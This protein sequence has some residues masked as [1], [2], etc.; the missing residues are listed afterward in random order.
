VSRPLGRLAV[1]L[2][3]LCGLWA[4]GATPAW[5]QAVAPEQATS[6]LDCH[7]VTEQA[8]TCRVAAELE[9]DRELRELLESGFTNHLVY[10]VYLFALGQDDP[11]AVSLVAFAQVFRLYTDVYYI[12]REGIDGY[13]ERLDWEAAAAELSQFE[14]SFGPTAELTPGDY[15]AVAL[16]EINP[17]DEAALAEARNWIAQSHGGYRLFGGGGES[18]F[19]SFVT[20]FVET[21]PGGAQARRL[22]QSP[23]FAILPTVPPSQPTPGQTPTAPGGEEAAPGTPPT[24]LE[25][26]P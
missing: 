12:S 4:A 13:V 15:F 9:G 8:L 23:A 2:A 6:P 19:G 26:G 7:I 25:P 14:V 24:S 10:R 18:L 20:L 3:C 22:Y 16:L 17:L 21:D 1:Q 11:T 5:S